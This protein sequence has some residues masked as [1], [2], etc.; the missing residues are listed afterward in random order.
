MLCEGYINNNPV[1]HS[2][3]ES[4]SKKDGKVISEAEDEKMKQALRGLG[5][6]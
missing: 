2:Q 1:K 3:R 6:L 5:Y 4:L